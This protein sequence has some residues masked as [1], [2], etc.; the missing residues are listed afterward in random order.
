MLGGDGDELMDDDDLLDESE[1]R[2]G[3]DDAAVGGREPQ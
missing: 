1:L 2:A 3:A